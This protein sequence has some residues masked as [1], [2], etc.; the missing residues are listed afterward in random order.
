MVN[1]SIFLLI[2]YSQIRLDIGPS[3][4]NALKD[5]GV[6]PSGQVLSMAGDKNGLYGIGLNSG[7]WKNQIDNNG[8]FGR[9]LS[10]GYGFEFLGVTSNPFILVTDFSGFSI[11]RLI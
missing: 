1:L 9:W 4:N 10:W 6:S 11:I 7:I 5:G 8:N 2:I 3:R